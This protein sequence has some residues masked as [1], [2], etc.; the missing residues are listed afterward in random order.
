MIFA[1][2]LGIIVA[3]MVDYTNQLHHS[4]LS[5]EEAILTACPIRLWPILMTSIATI[6]GAIFGARSYGPGADPRP[7]PAG[8]IGGIALSTPVTLIIVPVF[9]VLLERLGQRLQGL[10]RREPGAI[11][12]VGSVATMTVTK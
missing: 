9:Y 4:G 10:V 6:A 7:W 5:I 2:V 11:T 8:V 1:L 3:C 12:D